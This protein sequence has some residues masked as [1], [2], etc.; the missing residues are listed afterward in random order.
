MFRGGLIDEVASLLERGYSPELKA[1]EALGYRAVVRALR[2]ELSMDEAIELTKRDTRRY[3]KRQVTWFKREKD[4]Q[5][6]GFAG[7]DPRALQALLERV[8]GSR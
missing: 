6:I 4:M 3:A 7:E 2:G 1:F 5:W 8:R